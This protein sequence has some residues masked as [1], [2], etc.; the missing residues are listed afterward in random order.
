MNK[1]KKKI[2]KEQEKRLE[3]WNMSALSIN[4]CASYYLNSKCAQVDCA[5]FAYIYLHTL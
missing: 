5:H 4:V 3:K 2:K 1:S